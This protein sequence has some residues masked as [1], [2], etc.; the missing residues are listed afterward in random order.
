M[1]QVVVLSSVF[2]V[3]RY[4]FL[5]CVLEDAVDPCAVVG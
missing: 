1:L 4:L 3:G 5:F 2:T